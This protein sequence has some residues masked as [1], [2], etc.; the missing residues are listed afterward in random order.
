M[1]RKEEQSLDFEEKLSLLFDYQTFDGNADLQ[2]VIDAVH[3]RNGAQA[4][5]DD[6]A[7]LV[8][9]AGMPGTEQNKQ[10][11]WKEIE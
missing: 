11:P 10:L 3:S 2:A 4:L 8:A 9:A 1:E 6:E 5:S 7:E